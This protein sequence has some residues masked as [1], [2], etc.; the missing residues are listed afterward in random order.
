M[1]ANGGFSLATPGLGNQTQEVGACEIEPTPYVGNSGYC[2]LAGI[3]TPCF[4]AIYGDIWR[5]HS[6]AKANSPSLGSV[7]YSIQSIQ[8]R[9]I[10]SIIRPLIYTNF[11]QE[12]LAVDVAEWLR[13]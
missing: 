8:M 5:N 7:H 1:E 13:R 3:G 12:I 4:T 11:E 9:S 2:P 6:A 10:E